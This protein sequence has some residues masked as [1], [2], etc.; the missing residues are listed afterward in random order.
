MQLLTKGLED[1]IPNLY[2]TENI[3]V[4]EKIVY[5]KYFTPDA[6]WTWYVTEYSKTEK[7]FFGYVNG[8]YPEWGYF[9]LEE[10]EQVTGPLG[11]KIER[12]LHFEPTKFKDIKELKN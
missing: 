4:D 10:L 12:D 5:V 11:L 2:E 9:A 8:N 7:I 6:N 3:K 1:K